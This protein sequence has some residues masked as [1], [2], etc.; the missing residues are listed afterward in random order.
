MN[1]PQLL[2]PAVA[3]LVT[4]LLALA[5]C[6][7]VPQPAASPAPV[8]A[9]ALAALIEERF[10]A[11]AAAYSD[12]EEE[13]PA[14]GG[15][16]YPATPE[17]PSWGVGLGYGPG[18]EWASGAGTCTARSEYPVR[19]VERDGVRLAWWPSS[20]T[21]WVASARA[22][23]VVVASLA[24]VAVPK[25]P[26][27]APLSEQ[28]TALVAL[29][30]DPRADALA[31]APD[32]LETRWTDDPR[33]ASA[34]L[35]PLLAV[36]PGSGESA[37]PVTPQALVALIAERVRGTCGFGTSAHDD[38]SVSGTLYLAPGDG[39]RVTATLRKEVR[40]C[41]GMD[42]CEKRGD[43]TIA[44]QFDVPEEY[45]AT[46]EV[47]RRVAGG[48]LVLSHTSHHA[49]ATTRRFPVPLETLTAL[50]GDARFAF[51]V[52]PALNRA[53]TASPLCWRL[54]RPTGD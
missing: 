24:G 39:E 13:L 18:P 44:W 21:V 3:L 49:D 32:R 40:G 48:Q 22:A 30:A 19:C 47:T 25:D 53:G 16:W 34:A 27:S 46:V 41:Q 38:P 29:A 9:R 35:S 37:E 36:P 54:F 26:G 23:G 45:P 28:L 12:D 17:K 14:W 2:R 51:R 8:T 5:G 42:V 52:D 10:G 6:S 20:D 11:G 33:C 43:L 4:L 1:H 7:A 50:A 31:S 15:L